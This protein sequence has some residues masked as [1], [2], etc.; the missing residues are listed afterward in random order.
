L[1]RVSFFPF[2][3]PPFGVPEEPSRAGS[4]FGQPAGRGFSL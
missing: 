4:M 1:D 2:M 3:D